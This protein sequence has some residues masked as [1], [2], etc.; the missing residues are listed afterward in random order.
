MIEDILTVGTQGEAIFVRR[1]LTNG[2]R[3]ALIASES[4]RA[5]AATKSATL[6]LASAAPRRSLFAA[7][8]GTK[9][10]CL[11]HTQI[12]AHVAG[13]A[14]EVVRN[15][16]FARAGRNR[17]RVRIKTAIRGGGRT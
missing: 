5:K 10:D 17:E 15:N 3:S 4:L 7:S 12:E 8:T 16:L 11:A 13:P 14:T 9:S 1:T 2:S 6:T